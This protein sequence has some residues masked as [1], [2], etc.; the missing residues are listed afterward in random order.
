[1][2]PRSETNQWP[3]RYA[4]ARCNA[5]L[6]GW[7]I[8]LAG[9][10]TA[11]R[12]GQ[13]QVLEGQ[14]TISNVGITAAPLRT[15]HLSSQESD[16]SYPKKDFPGCFRGFYPSTMPIHPRLR[17]P[18]YGLPS[19]TQ[20]HLGYRRSSRIGKAPRFKFRVR[21][22][23]APKSYSH[24]LIAMPLVINYF[25]CKCLRSWKLIPSGPNGTYI[26]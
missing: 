7:R 9:A 3:N 11:L 18:L 12:S 4:G 20:T 8:S 21:R 2:T 23:V 1:M 15:R 17:A 24:G 25:N 14:L 22:P 16:L 6:G 10:L 5:E 26:S 19:S 13:Y